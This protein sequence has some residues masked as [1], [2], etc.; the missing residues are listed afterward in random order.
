LGLR[1]ARAADR[2]D[3]CG[4]SMG[5]CVRHVWIESSK[6]HH[7]AVDVRDPVVQEKIIAFA[8][9][10]D[11]RLV[12]GAITCQWL[13]VYR[14]IQKVDHAEREANRLTLDS[15]LCLVNRSSRNGGAW[16]M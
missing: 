4:R 3:S 13:S 5:C 12:L 16:R 11:V 14:H 6:R 7:L 9:D 1:D 10:H 8:Q 2:R 15:C